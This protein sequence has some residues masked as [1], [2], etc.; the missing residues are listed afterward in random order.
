VGAVWH[1]T[2]HCHIPWSRRYGS[3]V[4]DKGVSWSIVVA[5]VVA[6]QGMLWKQPALHTKMWGEEVGWF[7]HSCVGQKIKQ[8]IA[9]RGTLGN[10]QL[11]LPFN[12]DMWIIIVWIIWITFR[13]P[14]S[15]YWKIVTFNQ[16]S[17]D[18][19]F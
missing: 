5:V 14:L 9:E 13:W 10:N 2:L 6:A 3:M 16:F 8:V 12:F 15:Y 1:C 4:Q 18:R 17:I 11:S 7:S 19:S